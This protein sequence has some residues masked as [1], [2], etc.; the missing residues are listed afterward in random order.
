MILRTPLAVQSMMLDASDILTWYCRHVSFLEALVF[1]LQWDIREGGSNISKGMQQPQERWTC[2]WEWRQADKNQSLLL[3]HS[4]IWVATR[5]SHL[6]LGQIFLI[7]ITWSRKHLTRVPRCV[8]FNWIQSQSG[9]Q[10]RLVI[11][12]ANSL[13][14]FIFLVCFIFWA[15]D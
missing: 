14:Q 11:M 7:Q 8:H 2:Q 1:S 10:P 4:S 12:S 6:H 9:Q 13:I 5:K 3:S 15:Q